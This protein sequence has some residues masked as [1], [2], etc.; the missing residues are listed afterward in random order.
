VKSPV[1]VNTFR[2]HTTV[3]AHRRARNTPTAHERPARTAWP[4]SMCVVRGRG[5]LELAAVTMHLEPMEHGTVPPHAAGACALLGTASR[6]NCISVHRRDDRTMPI[7]LIDRCL[8]SLPAVCNVLFAVTLPGALAAGYVTWP[9]V[10]ENVWLGVCLPMEHGTVPP[11]AAGAC[12]LLGTASRQNCISVHRRDDRTAPSGRSTVSPDTVLRGAGGWL[13]V[14]GD[15]HILT[16]GGRA[17]GGRLRF[18]TIDQKM[19]YTRKAKAK[20]L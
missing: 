1:K 15:L 10:A 17:R 8:F 7:V 2:A 11:H 18:H 16:R 14:C 20:N 6:Q 5:R 4:Q 13:L 12:A 9:Y 3:E 19:A